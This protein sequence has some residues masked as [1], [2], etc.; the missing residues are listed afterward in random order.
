M[1]NWRPVAWLGTMSYSLYVWHYIFTPADGP[2][3]R[4]FGNAVNHNPW[5]L[6]PSLACA[7][8]SYFF[9]EHPVMQLRKR[10]TTHR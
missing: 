9:F 1:L 4:M 3:P 7:V 6:I 2:W 5:W 10:F 8:A